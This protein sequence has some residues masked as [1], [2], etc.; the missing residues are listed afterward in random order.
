MILFVGASKE[1]VSLTLGLST[2]RSGMLRILC[3]LGRVLGKLR[4]LRV[5]FFLWTAA[6]G[7]I[8]TFDNLMLRGRSLANQCWMCHC[9]GES[10]D[11]L[12]LHCPVVHAL[13]VF[14]L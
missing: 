6:H 14:M 1:M 12:L 2:M 5:A 9:N 8:L 13:W 11:H 3:S 10:V 7:Q 4:F